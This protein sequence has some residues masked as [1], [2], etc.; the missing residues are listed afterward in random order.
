MIA[1]VVYIIAIPFIFLLGLTKQKYKNSFPSRF[2]LKNSARFP[3]H[4]LW[5]HACSLG[6][7]KSLEPILDAIDPNRCSLSVTTQTGYDY[8]QGRWSFP[9]RYLPFEIFLPFWVNQPD[10]VIVTEAEL[11]PALFYA[12]KKQKARTLLINA[13]MSERS[14]RRYQRLSWLY[15]RV[16][17]LIDGVYAQSEVD[18]QRLEALGAKNVHVFGNIKQYAI[19]NPTCIY[20]KSERWTVVAASTHEGEEELILKAFR[21][22]HQNHSTSRLVIVP[23][24]P[25]RFDKVIELCRSYAINRGWNF[26]Q[27]SLGDWNE[28]DLLVV[29]AMGELI[30]FYA[31]AD[32]VILGG[33]FVP[34]GGHN[35]IEPATLGC[36]LLTGEHIYHQKVL[37]DHIE[38]YQIVGRH[39]LTQALDDAMTMVPAQV[40]RGGDLDSLVKVICHG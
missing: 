40:K 21:A 39:D 18:K 20:E 33:S 22:H 7:T 3:S 34:V 5:F 8:A 38:N 25:E 1:L 14:F 23:R 16:F 36:R 29:D 15:K 13:R 30:N 37:F 12:A 35:P 31:I 32:V 2:F 9:I 26:G 17:G 10:V 27:L 6:E 4:R 11:W 19:V 28:C 24:H